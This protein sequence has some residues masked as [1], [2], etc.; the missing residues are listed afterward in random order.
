MLKNNCSPPTERRTV[1]TGFLTTPWVSKKYKNSYHTSRQKTPITIYPKFHNFEIQKRTRHWSSNSFRP[2]SPRTCLIGRIARSDAMN[3]CC[4]TK[5]VAGNWLPLNPFPMIFVE[6]GSLLEFRMFP[7]YSRLTPLRN[8]WACWFWLFPLNV[9]PM[10]VWLE[11]GAKISMN[12]ISSVSIL[13]MWDY[14]R[15]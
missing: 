11:C 1:L 14:L 2:L 8:R 5:K 3:T 13:G 12:N 9:T 15:M 6:R 10:F 7:V 4:G